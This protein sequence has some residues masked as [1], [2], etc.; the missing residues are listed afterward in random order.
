MR[1][2]SAAEMVAILAVA[3]AGSSQPAR[4]SG[5][6]AAEGRRTDSAGPLSRKLLNPTTGKNA[7]VFPFVEL[8]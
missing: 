4:S 1:L 7:Q 5:R 6:A 8:R 3:S 2:L